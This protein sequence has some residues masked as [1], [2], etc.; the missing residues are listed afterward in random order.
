MSVRLITVLATCLIL[1][2]GAMIQGQSWGQRVERDRS[3]YDKAGPYTIDYEPPFNGEKNLGEIR[4]FLWQH[5]KNRSLGVVEATFFT[6]EGD[7]TFSTF[8]VESDVKGCWRIRIE[9]E[10]KIG[11]LLPRGRKPR[12]KITREDYDLIDRLEAN[13][14]T[15]VPIPLAEIRLP[16]NYKLRL[17]NSRTNAVRIF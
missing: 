9:S 1:Q 5:W 11:A 8:L 16:Q 14:S 15:G 13:S 10:S 7:S 12:R 2:F 4:G 3:A 6:I 17:R